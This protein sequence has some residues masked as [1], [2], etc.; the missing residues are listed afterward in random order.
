MKVPVPTTEELAVLH[1][2]N[3]LSLKAS[4]SEKIVSYLAQIERALVQDMGKYPAHLFPEGSFLKPGK[5]SKGENYLGMPYFVLD[6]PRYF[7]RDEVFAYRNMVWWGNFFSCTLHLSGEVFDRSRPSIWQWAQQQEDCFICVADSPWRYEY[8]SDNY[9][10]IG[11][12]D[13]AQLE[14]IIFE[15]KFLKISSFIP[16][17]HWDKFG[18]FSLMNLARFMNILV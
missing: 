8:S 2:T 1:N 17:G 9:L 15:K 16:L 5:I 11:D 13:M 7:T 6:C 3:Y 12:L 10:M 18:E 14:R 4:V